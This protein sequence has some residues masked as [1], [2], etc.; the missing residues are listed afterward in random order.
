MNRQ[1]LS[2]EDLEEL[3]EEIPMDRLGSTDEVAQLVLKVADA[4][5]YMTGQVITIDGGW[6]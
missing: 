2:K 5:G 4:P 6:I 1:H 3:R